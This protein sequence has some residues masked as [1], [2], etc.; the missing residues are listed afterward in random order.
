MY[1]FNWIWNPLVFYNNLAK[2]GKWKV[3]GK[4]NNL[5]FSRKSNMPFALWRHRTHHLSWRHSPIYVDNEYVDIEF[6]SEFDRELAREKFSRITTVFHSKYLPSIVR[7]FYWLEF[8]N[9]NGAVTGISIST[10]ELRV[11]HDRLGSI[12]PEKK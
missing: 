8:N 9:I 12:S 10:F 6:D 3:F 5:L 4:F 1:E 2:E 11:I 7:M